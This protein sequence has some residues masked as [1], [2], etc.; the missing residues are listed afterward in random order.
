MTTRSINFL[1]RWIAN[2]MPATAKADAVSISELTHKLY[3]DAKALGI[4]REEIDEEVGSLYRTLVDAVVHL[5]PGL[6]LF[7]NQWMEDTIC[8]TPVRLGNKRK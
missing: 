3:A 6:V 2:N 1:D 4:K 7:L 5:D 8:P